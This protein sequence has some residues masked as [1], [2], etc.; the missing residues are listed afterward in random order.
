M[1]IYVI[2]HVKKYKSSTSSKYYLNHLQFSNVST[3]K[4]VILKD[5]M[6]NEKSTQPLNIFNILHQTNIRKSHAKRLKSIT[7]NKISFIDYK[8]IIKQYLCEIKELQSDQSTA[9]M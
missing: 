8:T 9:I 1:N 7:I 6:L 4:T 5:K 2:I 3:D